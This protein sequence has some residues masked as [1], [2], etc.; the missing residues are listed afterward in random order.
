[1][2]L[3]TG[4]RVP[5]RRRAGSRECLRLTGTDAGRAQQPCMP[6]SR[7]VPLPERR[8]WVWG[9]QASTDVRQQ[10]ALVGPLIAT[11]FLRSRPWTCLAGDRKRN[12][13]T[14]PGTFRRIPPSPPPRARTD[15]DS[16]GTT[17]RGR[18]PLSTPRPSPL[19]PWPTGRPDRPPSPF[20]R[21][22]VRERHRPLFPRVR[23]P[24]LPP[25]TLG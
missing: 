8:V 10:R 9:R 20:P 3:A 12:R 23:R 15:A 19:R 16:S 2:A 14:L 13:I 24:N 11:N 18:D 17:E 7:N 21:H 6:G 4:G 25:R 22:S 5:C 1:M